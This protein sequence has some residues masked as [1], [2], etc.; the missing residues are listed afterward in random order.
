MKK[1]LKVVFVCIFLASLL[2]GSAASAA[3][4]N[5][6]IADGAWSTG[7][8]VNV[9]LEANPAPYTWL[10]LLGKG[11]VIDKPGVICHPF[12][13][14]RYGW[15]ADIRQLVGGTW[16]KVTTMQ[17]WVSGAESTYQAC[18]FAPSAGT[19]ALFGYYILPEE[20]T[21]TKKATCEYDTSEWTAE[22]VDNEGNIA[23]IVNLQDDFPDGLAASFELLEV[24]DGYYSAPTSE[25]A[26]TH[27]DERK[28]GTYVIFANEK[29]YDGAFTITIRFTT[30]G[31]TQDFE[32]S[33]D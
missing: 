5:S 13:G 4:A 24:V 25:S 14:G 1:G 3:K 18:A 6:G 17:D 20:T 12:E 32:L 2:F 19:Y 8:E 23:F 31:C 10:Q 22:I 21:T 29:T 15:T 11:V 9:D 30:A 28:G 26:T 7:T 33:Y 27:Y 16:T